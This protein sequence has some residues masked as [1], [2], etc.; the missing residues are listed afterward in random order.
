MDELTLLRDLDA[1]APA[2]SARTRLAARTRLQREIAHPAGRIRRRSWNGQTAAALVLA[3]TVVGALVVVVRDIAAG[4]GPVPGYVRL[5]DP[6]RD[7]LQLAARGP[8]EVALPP[9]PRPDQY[10]YTRSITVVTPIGPQGNAKTFEEEGWKSMARGQGLSRGCEIGRCWTTPGS[11][12]APTGEDLEKIPRDPRRLLL[13]AR[14]WLDPSP[15]SGPFTEYDW[16][17]SYDFLFT[18]LATPLVVPPDLRSALVRA[19]AYTPDA[20]VIDDRLDFHGR[21]AA[22]ID[23]PTWGSDLVIDRYTYEPLGSRW[24]LGPADMGGRNRMFNASRA[25]GESRLVEVALVDRF[26]ERP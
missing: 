9:Q 20:R 17:N 18:L 2:L 12:W 3:L 19:L 24:V 10:L 23:V 8:D 16:V 26:K 6:D 5:A 14:A 25:R 15:P 11:S 13:Y 1:D 7:V 21:P 22:L 4:G